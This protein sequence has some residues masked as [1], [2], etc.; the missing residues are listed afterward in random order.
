MRKAVFVFAAAV[1]MWSCGAPEGSAVKV[2]VGARIEN[3]PLE[4]SVVVIS[5]GEIRAVGA[6]SAVPVP[7]GSQITSGLGMTVE[8]L[9]GAG[10][11]TAGSPANLVLKGAARRVMRN[12]EWVE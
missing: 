7:K 3:P 12:G 6:Q 1:W 5:G 10:P 2:I 4:H 11:L 8:P 9:D